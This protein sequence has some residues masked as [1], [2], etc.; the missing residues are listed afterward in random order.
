VSADADGGSFIETAED[1]VA[2]QATK[3]NNT[4]GV[5]AGT[6]P[7]VESGVS[8]GNYTGQRHKSTDER[9]DIRT[10]D[11]HAS[12]REVARACHVQPGR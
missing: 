11:R 3:D 4:T 9:T 6:S 10:A 5:G 7:P 2:E 1:D 8:N 12:W